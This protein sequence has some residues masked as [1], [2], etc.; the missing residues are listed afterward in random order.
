M[1]PMLYLSGFLLL[2]ANVEAQPI[3]QIVGQLEN[4]HHAKVISVQ[5]RRGGYRVRLLQAD[6]VVKTIHYRPDDWTPPTRPRMRDDEEDDV[7]EE[8]IES[9]R[10]HSP[11]RN[12]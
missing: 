11:R 4:E 9:N 10:Q 3:D 1:F 8:R 5:Q 2:A 12:P 6:G 7:R